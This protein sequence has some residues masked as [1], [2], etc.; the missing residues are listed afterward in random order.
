[1]SL[2]SRL[3]SELV[4]FTRASSGWRFN[5]L[6]T[7]EEVLNN[8]PRFDFDPVTLAPLGL[9]M[10]P[11]RT[12]LFLNTAIPATQGI[13][14]TATDYT[15]SFTG[16]GSITLSGAATG[17]LTGTGASDRVSLTFSPSAGTLTLTVSGTIVRPQLEKGAF[18]TSHIPV[19]G[20]AV[21]R[22][23]EFAYTLLSDFAYNASA[24]T[25]IINGNFTAGQRILRLGALEVYADETG[26]KSYTVS[27]DETP[28]GDRIQLGFGTFR[29]VAYYPTAFGDIDPQDNPLWLF[30]LGETGVFL[31]L[32][33]P[34]VFSDTAG[35][36]PAEIGE[37]IAFFND[38]VTIRAVDYPSAFFP[39]IPI[40]FGSGDTAIDAA[41]VENAAISN[42]GVYYVKP[43]TGNDAND[44]TEAAPFAT[45]SHA[46]RT[47]TGSASRV[48]M[49]EDAVIEP[50]DLR[51]TD[52]SQ[53]TQ[54][55]K[56]L[57]ANGFNVTI[58]TSGPALSAQTWVQD[59]TFTNCYKTTLAIGA[60]QQVTRVL[61][62]TA[63]DYG[64]DTPLRKYTSASALNS[65]TDHGWYWD[66]SGKVLWINIG[67]A[68]VEAQ[69]ANYRALYL[70]TAGTSRLFIYGAALGLSG[71]NMEGVQIVHLDGDGIRPEIWMQ[72]VTQL[73]STGKGAD[74]RGWY[75]ATN[76]DI[77]ASEQDGCNAF[78]AWAGGKSLIQTVNCRFIRSGDRRTF[79]LNGT[80]QGVSA[81]GGSYHISF[82]S[83]FRENNG[84]GVADTCVN[85]STDFSWLRDCVVQGGAA[86]VTAPNILF[87]SA[88]T[89]ALRL[90]FIS[91]IT[92]TDAATT[93]LTID[94]NSQVQSFG[95]FSGVVSGNLSP[96]NSKAVQVTSTARPIFAR[97]PYGGK[98]NFAIY[99]EELTN[100]SWG[101]TN[102][103]VESAG[104]T[105][106]DGSPVFR[107]IPSDATGVVHFAS[108][109]LPEIIAGGTVRVR[110]KIESG[111]DKITLYPS[112]SATFSHFNLTA[113]TSASEA[114]VLSTEIVPVGGGYYDLI[115]K[116]GAGVSMDR[117]RVYA[118]SGIN[119]AAPTTEDG[120]SGVLVT[121]VQIETGLVATDYQK[122][123]TIYDITESGIPSVY[124]ANLDGV[125]DIIPVTLPTITGGTVAL[126][127]LNGIWIE[128]DW[129]FT[130]GTLNIGPTTIAGLPAGILS[131]VGDLCAVIINDRAWTAAE[132]A[133]VIAWGKARG[134][135]G[136][137]A[138]GEE[139]GADY[140]G[141]PLDWVTSGDYSITGG[142][143]QKVSGVS[144]GAYYAASTDTSDYLVSFNLDSGSGLSA[145]ST[146]FAFSDN[147]SGA[148][149][150]AKLSILS[151]GETRSIL[152][153]T[154]QTG[155]RFRAQT[156]S[157]MVV[158]A[159]SVRKLE[160]IP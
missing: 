136:V 107:L 3:F 17:T 9:I 160:L 100:V 22:A 14:V 29:S 112:G 70:G 42:A 86:G 110:A 97:A 146:W 15:L 79:D 118:S 119:G 155:F 73:W 125:D 8:L 74:V 144:S 60:S 61:S 82:G 84:Q 99:T 80:L 2:Q 76:S 77:Y 127:G 55:F 81:H 131:V 49:L 98:R 20:T 91:G 134:A 126:V 27:Y 50:F 1:M 135:P 129:D 143:L 124:Y 39:D 35:T 48:L 147:A 150:G 104:E 132:R 32:T 71:V 117:F 69:K 34:Q 24:G 13:T 45:V 56:W 105:C 44:G 133:W 109:N 95:T 102:V 36:N 154:G 58:R 83:E 46:M 122:V 111:I 106:P 11:A 151:V 25:L 108:I 40:E 41:L 30:T 140:F 75:I 59:G 96:Y 120:I 33:N 38:R 139:L 114:N 52:A 90:G 72:N 141:D 142:T 62:T 158:D 65:G 6:G 92:S 101:K 4:T 47:A 137:F 19:A 10:E 93:D 116:Y 67:G 157:T 64:F 57:D 21:A 37:G 159:L 149:E 115:A 78:Q 26:D 63:D 145:L 28:G 23:E 5:E 54:Q 123:T 113:L 128:D 12:N 85:S 88:A 89:S 87:G 53:S 68:D 138:L 121:R 31:D 103:S 153:S 51:F 130:A 7:F 43:S 156:T 152:A 66:N 148:N 16:V 18:V 94:V